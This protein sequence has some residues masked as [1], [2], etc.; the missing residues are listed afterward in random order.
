M[1]NILLMHFITKVSNP[2]SNT[3]L[4]IIMGVSGSGKSTI[5][6]AVA[7]HYQYCF[8]DADDFH[9]AENKKHMANGLPLTDEM[10]IPWVNSLKNYLESARSDHKH[11]VL[12]F[13]G[14]KKKHRDE[15]RKAGLKTIFIFLNGDKDIIQAR[16]NSRQNHFMNPGLVDSQFAAL[17]DPTQEIDVHSIAVNESLDKVLNEVVT[18]VDK[19]LLRG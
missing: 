18:Q 10:R 6:K 16:V 13:S 9:S 15:L 8:L 3:H 1:W 5:A 11:C 2:N 19:Y 4:I 7:D 12:A 14:L 17:E